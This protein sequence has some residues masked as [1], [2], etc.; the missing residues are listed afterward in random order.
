MN[1]I[2]FKC[3]R[4][5]QVKAAQVFLDDTGVFVPCDCDPRAIE[6]EHRAEVEKRMQHMAKQQQ[7]RR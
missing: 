7:K 5:G 3:S 2:Q 1:K 6:L 4:C